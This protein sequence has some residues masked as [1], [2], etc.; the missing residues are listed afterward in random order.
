MPEDEHYKPVAPSEVTQL[1][2]E[3]KSTPELFDQLMPLVYDDMRR[4]GHAQ[5]RRLGAGPTM[6]TTAL[7]HEAFLKLRGNL[8]HGIEGKLHFQRLVACVMRQLILDYIRKRLAAKR[9]GDQ[10]RMTYEEDQYGLAAED[11]DRI[12]AVEEVLTA[13]FE[14]DRRMAEVAAAQLY[15]GYT[16]EEIA[17]MLGISTRTVV[18]DLQRARAWLR[19]EL[20]DFEDDPP[21]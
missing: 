20:A 13:L 3:I 18:R 11:L 6:Q 16:V 10:V 4:I 5:R 2:G 7:V 9:G 19:V 14:R 15:A 21:A 12:M 17:E 1:L 8:G